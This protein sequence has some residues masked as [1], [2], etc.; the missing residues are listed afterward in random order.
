[1]WDKKGENLTYK[2]IKLLKEQM[3]VDP[4]MSVNPAMSA[5]Q[6]TMASPQDLKVA[7]KNIDQQV[8]KISVTPA[9]RDWETI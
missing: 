2:F 5:P 8:K 3:S 1:M 6:R 7:R 9:D 4:G